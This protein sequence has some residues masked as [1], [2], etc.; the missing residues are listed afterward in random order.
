MKPRKQKTDLPLVFRILSRIRT[1]IEKG[2]KT[3]KLR[4]KILRFL[5]RSGV[6]VKNGLKIYRFINLYRY[7]IYEKQVG[8]EACSMCQL[9]CPLCPTVKGLNRKGVVGWGYLKAEHFKKFVHSNPWIKRIELPNYG[10]VFL[11][12]EIKDIFEYAHYKGVQLTI[13]SGTNFNT[14]SQD[15][16]ESLVKY[17]ITDIT[18]SLDGTS[19][20][21]YQIYRKG[22]N[23]DQVIKNIRT[24]NHYKQKYNSEFPRLAW[25]FVVFGH[26]EHEIPKAREKAAKLGMTFI[27]SFNW[28]PSFSPI[29]DREFVKRETG[30]GVSS[31]EEFKEKYQVNLNAKCKQ[32]WQSPQINWDGKLLGCCVNLWD[33]FGNV[34]DSGLRNCLKSEKY[35]YAK[36]MLLGKVPAREDIP[37]TKCSIYIKQ[38]S[39][40]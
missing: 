33:D 24:V 35:N 14:V 26:N 39:Q 38:F 31:R 30:L 34:F 13:I 21:T 37:C 11:N 27:P 36:K 9:R 3:G 16:I 23:F 6:K 17:K 8:L 15:V 10:E 28:D 1:R 32:L 20:E 29:K 5:Y 18:I 25:Q 4:W 7:G 12:P 40:K 19:N 22:G 2:L